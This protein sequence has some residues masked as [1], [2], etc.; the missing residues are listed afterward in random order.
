MNPSAALNNGEDATGSSVQYRQDSQVSAAARVLHNTSLA[1]EAR[2][3]HNS[4]RSDALDKA[5]VIVSAGNSIISVA[6]NWQSLIEKVELFNRIVSA[7][8]EVCCD[9]LYMRS[10]CSHWPYARFILMLRLHC[11]F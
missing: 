5:E 3:G 8:S 10:N 4:D 7:I 1:L 2:A 9:P 11:L 6:E